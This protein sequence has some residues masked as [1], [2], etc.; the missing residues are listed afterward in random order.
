MCN[1]SWKCDCVTS[2]EKI[3][4]YLGDI[5]SSILKLMKVLLQ[6]NKSHEIFSFSTHD[7]FLNS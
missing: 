2:I 4:A 6:L 3:Q 1:A 7:T 5:A